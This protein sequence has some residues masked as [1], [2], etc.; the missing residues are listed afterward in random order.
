MSKVTLLDRLRYAS[1]N[2]FSKGSIVLIGWLAVVT[3][4]IIFGIAF[5]V[6]VTGVAPGYDFL[7]LAWMGLMRTLDSGTM[8]G[9]EG[10][11]P[12]L[13]AMLAVTLAGVFVLSTLIGILTSAI[14]ARLESL[15][16]GRSRVI[17]SNHT[18]VLGWS[19]Q[20][21]TIVSELAEANANQRGRC[22]V[23]LAPQDKV[24]MEDAIREKV[25]H[26]GHTRIVC[27]TGN[28]IEIGDLEISNLSASRAIIIL[29]PEQEN[30]DA[31]VIKTLLAITHA[32][33]RRAE[34]Y[35]IVAELREPKN[36]EVAKMVGRDE[37]EIVLAGDLVAR[38]IAQMCRQSGLSVVYSDLLDFAGSEIY[39]QEEPALVGKSLAE[40]LR[41]YESSCVIGLQKA[42]GTA[43]LNPPLDTT[44]VP[45]DRVI[46]IAADDDT[47]VLSKRTEF[48][49]NMGAIRTQPPGRRGPERALILGWNWR[50]PA[51]INELDNYVAQGSQV[52]VVADAPGIEEE[53]A[54]RCIGL[55]NQTLTVQ[56][57]DTTDR[58]LL[59]A[60]NIPS[61][62]HVITLS[63]SDLLGVQQADSR[64]LI[65]LLHLRDI[66]ERA[67]RRFSVIS[68]MLDLRNRN[69]A[70]VTNA[71]DI[72]VSERMIS[73]VIAQV[74][75]N[76]QLNRLF[77]DIFDAAGSEI[78]LKPMHD[79]VEL[80][81]PLNFYT[82]LEAAARRGEIAIGYRRRALS[83]DSAQ[84]Y[85]VVLNPH[86]AQEV[87]FADGD[88]IIVFAEE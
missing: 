77:T 39:F 51:I 18:V 44:I 5:V 19:Q 28:P 88:S 6:W 15:R 86:K 25:V 69:L 34:P 64:T 68:E 41:A 58:R 80:G 47:I 52:Y 24:E 49:I 65:T 70:E 54:A 57:G 26:R 35:H 31:E 55:Q 62:H 33:N 29:S 63:Y 81:T 13:L 67:G 66:A 61:F 32:P 60:L 84:N 74:A 40:A 1:D 36:L 48:G 76:K 78:Y 23:I 56:R 16:K 72:I 14:D 8:G 20:I 4:I 27:R 83:T 50:A 85:G 12:F 22:I 17:E 75:E 82:V 71:D 11:W 3:A 38:I 87:V 46:A 30:P 37:V 2:A 42:D 79:Y 59:D 43:R 21:F 9:D 7:H 45:G 10:S 73:L 53:I